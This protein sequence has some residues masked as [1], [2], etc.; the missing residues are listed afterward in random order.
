[1]SLHS[2]WLETD[3][4]GQAATTR[5]KSTGMNSSQDEFPILTRSSA[6]KM[7]KTSEDLADHIKWRSIWDIPVDGCLAQ[8]ARKSSVSIKIY[9][10]P[11]NTILSGDSLLRII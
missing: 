7:G 4:N 2:A 6:W 9:N 3:E 5:E 8:P 11:R 1:M 10:C